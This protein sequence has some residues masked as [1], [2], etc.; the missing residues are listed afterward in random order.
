M[1]NLVLIDPNQSRA[2][3]RVLNGIVATIDVNNKIVNGPVYPGSVV[4]LVLDQV[5]QKP[6]LLNGLIR[7]GDIEVVEDGVSLY[8]AG[9]HNK[10]GP[11][12]KGTS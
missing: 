7:N 1:T 9:S 11:K 8:L 6:K 2:R 5:Y 12:P 3:V 4:N 10:P